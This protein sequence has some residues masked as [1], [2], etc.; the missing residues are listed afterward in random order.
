MDQRID[1]YMK[2]PLKFT[3]EDSAFTLDDII[4]RVMSDMDKTSYSGVINNLE[5]L[6]E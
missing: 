3:S 1:D 4:T 5:S 2:H 6:S